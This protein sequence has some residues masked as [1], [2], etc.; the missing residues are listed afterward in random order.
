MAKRVVLA[1]SGGLDTSVAVRWLQ[2]ELGVEVIAVALN[3]GQ[4]GDFDVVR[5][6]A[7]A[8]GAVEAVVVDARAEMARGLRGARHR[9]Q[10]PLRGQV[11]AR[12][13][14]VA[15]GHRAPSGGRGP[16]A[17]RRCRGPRLYREGQRPGALRGG[18]P[19]RWPPTS[20]SW[21]RPAPGA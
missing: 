5:K 3:V 1:H 11:P 21:P 16:P 18:R 15:P 4:G 10:C 8:A 19:A 7:L 17:R 13:G 20:R 6:R 12:L 9:R 2:E 14:A